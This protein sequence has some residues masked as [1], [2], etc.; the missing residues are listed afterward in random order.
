MDPRFGYIAPRKPSLCRVYGTPTGRV[1]G[2]PAFYILLSSRVYGPPKLLFRNHFSYRVYEA[3]IHQK[4][5]FAL[6]KLLCRTKP[7][8]QQKAATNKFGFGSTSNNYMT[9][10]LYVFMLIY[11]L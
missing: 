6:M 11:F 8:K 7:I 2:T 5:M 1:Y 3:L 10:L 4:K 9:H